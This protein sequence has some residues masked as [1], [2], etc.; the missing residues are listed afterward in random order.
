MVFG[1]MQN[2]RWDVGRGFSHSRFI[3][4]HSEILII[5]IHII[6]SQ[7]TVKTVVKASNPMLIPMLIIQDPTIDRAGQGSGMPQKARDNKE[8]PNFNIDALPK[9]MGVRLIHLRDDR[10]LSYQRYS[11]QE[12]VGMAFQ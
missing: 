7:I 9:V 10:V 8:L 11:A 4:W 1:E 6:A 5:H 12:Y 3:Y 2:L